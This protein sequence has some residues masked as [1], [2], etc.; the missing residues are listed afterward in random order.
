MS[1]GESER[2]PSIPSTYLT[3]DR[4][5]SRNVPPLG[6]I[7]QASYRKGKVEFMGLVSPMVGQSY[8]DWVLQLSDAL[9]TYDPG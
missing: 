1:M 9:A 5:Y 2:F 8:P 4:G 3:T 7:C 6:V